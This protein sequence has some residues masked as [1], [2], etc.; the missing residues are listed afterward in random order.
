MSDPGWRLFP[1]EQAVADWAAHARQVAIPRTQDMA[2]FPDWLRCG[3][4]WFVGVNLLPNDASGRLPGGP[5]L[6]GAAMDYL[7][8]Q[9][10]MAPLD[11][12][13]VSVIYPG[14]PQPSSAESPAA[15]RFRRDRDAAHVDGLLPEGPE[16]RRHLRE[17]HAFVLGLPLNAASASPMVVWEG[18]HEIMRAAFSARLDGIEPARWPETDLTE[19]Y[20]AA[21]K[22][23]FALCPR[24]EIRARPG[25]AYLIHRLALHGVAPWRD[26]DAASPEGRMIAY[27]RPELACIETWLA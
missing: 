5:P 18:S 20:H 11:Q 24:V 21:R 3:G 8:A 13:Q 9:A 7:H 17:P 25:E 16:K 26:G 6:D 2:L 19:T 22:Q 4:T 27:F 10:M 14:Y 1:F 12:A 15:H 23:C